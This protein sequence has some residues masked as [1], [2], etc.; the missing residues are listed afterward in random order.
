MQDGGGTLGWA[1]A[2]VLGWALSAWIG[3]RTAGRR[4]GNK[5]TALYATAFIGTGVVLTLTAAIGWST[6]TL[7]PRGLDDVIHGRVRLAV[8]AYLA[9]AT[10]A[11]VG[12]LKAQV[13]VSD[14][15]LSTHLRKLEE[16]G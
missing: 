14:G 8:M 13:G 12:H 3:A 7:D 15:N 16:A 2:I 11:E 1:V 9:T 4:P 6:G 5:L 10:S